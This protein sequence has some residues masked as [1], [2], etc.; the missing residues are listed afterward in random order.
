MGF[1]NLLGKGCR[2]MS[3]MKFVDPWKAKKFNKKNAGTVFHKTL[4]SVSLS[5]SKR[6]AQTNN[7]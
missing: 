3:K 2:N 4:N 1:G 6:N 7:C 5:P